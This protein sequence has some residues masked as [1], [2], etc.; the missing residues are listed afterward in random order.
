MARYWLIKPLKLSLTADLGVTNTTDAHSCGL[1]LSYIRWRC[2]SDGDV[3]DWFPKIFLQSHSR[4]IGYPTIGRNASAGHG[5]PADAASGTSIASTSMGRVPWTYLFSLYD[6][7]NARWMIIR[8]HI[9]VPVSQ[10]F[11]PKR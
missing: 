7:R 5:G 6:V 2:S 11:G 1:R 10:Y 4:I 3:E 8:G 9:Q